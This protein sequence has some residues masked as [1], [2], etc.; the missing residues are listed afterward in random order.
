MDLKVGEAENKLFLALREKIVL[1][2]CYLLFH[3][4][5]FDYIRGAV[6]SFSTKG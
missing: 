4:A 3:L 2:H 5:L 1:A 6:K